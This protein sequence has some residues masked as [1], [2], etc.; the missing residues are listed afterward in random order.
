[1]R[2]LTLMTRSMSASEQGSRLHSLALMSK[3]RRS[4][5]HC[6]TGHGRS[7]DPLAPGSLPS[8]GRERKAAEQ[9]PDRGPPVAFSTRGMNKR[10]AACRRWWLGAMVAGTVLSGAVS[11]LPQRRPP[12][13]VVDYYSLLP[14]SYFEIDRRSLLNPR[15]GGIVDTKNGYLPTWPDG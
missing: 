7:A 11:S 5:G 1:M 14:G 8:D 2:W 10:Q 15:Y 13:T 6:C 12:Q 4:R 3:Q 9:G